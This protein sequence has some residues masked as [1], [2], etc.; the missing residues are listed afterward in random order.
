MSHGRFV[1]FFLH[2][3]FESFSIEFEAFLFRHQF[4]QIDWESHGC[5]Q[6][7]RIFSLKDTIL[8]IGFCQFI[9]FLQ[10]LIQGLAKGFFFFR[11]DRRHVRFLC[12][13]FG[14]GSAHELH[15]RG[16]ELAKESQFG[17]Q[18]LASVPHRTTQDTPQYVSPSVVAG[19]GSVGNSKGEGTNVIGYNSVGHVDQSHVFFCSHLACVWFCVWNECADG[20]KDG[21]ENVCIVVGLLVLKDTS[22]T[23]E[24]HTSINVLGWEWS[25]G[26][27][28]FAI[29]LD[30]DIVPDFNH[31]WKIGIHKF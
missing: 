6:K 31:I 10:S 15:H 18:I 24:T 30:K 19:H 3:A 27:I 8:G 22:E 23:F 12:N 9:E 7:L 2:L 13:E 26:T 14:K 1:L 28:G 25:Q 29:V 11:N 20:F 4:R 17:S 21:Y 5:V 16:H